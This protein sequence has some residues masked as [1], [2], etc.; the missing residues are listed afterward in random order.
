MIELGD[1]V[2]GCTSKSP[3]RFLL[4]FPKNP[5]RSQLELSSLEL[6]FAER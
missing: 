4:R 3:V 6:L 2:L 5:M 1:D